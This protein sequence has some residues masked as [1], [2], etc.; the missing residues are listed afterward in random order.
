MVKWRFSMSA[1]PLFH[2]FNS[3]IQ[4]RW[5]TITFLPF[6]PPPKK[7]EPS[8]KNIMPSCLACIIT[9]TKSERDTFIQQSCKRLQLYNTLKKTG[10]E[11]WRNKALSSNPWISRTQN[12]SST[13]IAVSVATWQ[14]CS[15]VAIASHIMAMVGW[16]CSSPKSKIFPVWSFHHNS[17]TFESIVVLSFHVYH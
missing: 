6:N 15:I 4:S 9:S 3:Y 8:R 2:S 1:H 14:N 13:T 11:S 12:A 10:L 5:R 17:T 7:T 16:R